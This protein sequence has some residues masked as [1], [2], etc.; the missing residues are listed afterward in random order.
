MEQRLCNQDVLRRQGK[1]KMRREGKEE[2]A[3]SRVR[4]RWKPRWLR[5]R[6]RGKCGVV[7]QWSTCSKSCGGGKKSRRFHL[8]RGVSASDYN[9]G[10]A[11]N[12]LRRSRA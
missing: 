3:L 12:G 5:L 9:C 1:E 7:G 8:P 11:N 6:R 10:A 2:K 4:L